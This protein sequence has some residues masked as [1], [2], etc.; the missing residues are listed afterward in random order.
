MLRLA[1]YYDQ[2]VEQDLKTLSA[3]IEPAALM[4]MGTIIGVMVSSII[5]PMF[6]LAH[7]IK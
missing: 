4:V 1:E 5:L 2:E 7:A 6:R 3:L